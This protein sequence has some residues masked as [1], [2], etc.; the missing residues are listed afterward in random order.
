MG[1]DRLEAFDEDLKNKFEIEYQS[2]GKPIAEA[3]LAEL[4]EK[5]LGVV[6]TTNNT[7][8]T[9]ELPEESDDDDI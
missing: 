6:S 3:K 7:S 8:T 5:S 9:P 1:R 2:Q 4:K